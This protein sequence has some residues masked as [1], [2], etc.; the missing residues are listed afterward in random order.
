[1]F[2]RG[3]VE[4]ILTMANLKLKP[5][6]FT[7]RPKKS[8]PFLPFS[9]LLANQR[10]IFCTKSW[11]VTQK[12]ENYMFIYLFYLKIIK[13][14]IQKKRESAKYSPCT[15]MT[16]KAP[17]VTRAPFSNFPLTKSTISDSC[18]LLCSKYFYEMRKPNKIH[19]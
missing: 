11:S 14:K 19:T 4:H 16:V 13:T 2:K 7:P 3:Q 9:A 15:S 1:M 5:S 10:S 6:L 18:L 17:S 12:K 8:S